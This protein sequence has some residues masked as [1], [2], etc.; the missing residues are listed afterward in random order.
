MKPMAWNLTVQSILLPKSGLRPSECEDAIGI[1]RD[2]GR[3]CIADGAT[4][5]FDSRR[6]AR[7]LTK[8]WVASTRILTREELRSWLKSLSERFERHWAKRSLPW[9]TEEKA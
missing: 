6:W 3:F 2:L 7:L 9:Y 8:H 1:R 4:E 5:G